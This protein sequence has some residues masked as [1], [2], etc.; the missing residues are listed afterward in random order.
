LDLVL[1]MTHIEGHD[2][3]DCTQI[4]VIRA[5]HVAAV[6]TDEVF[7]RPSVDVLQHACG[8]RAVHT[9]AVARWILIAHPF[10][11]PLELPD[12]SPVKPEGA[13]TEFYGRT[14]TNVLPNVS[15]ALGGS[16]QV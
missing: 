3:H 16:G 11:G 15:I 6:V 10:I 9:G 14:P 5:P 1:G 13:D 2:A 4:R 12:V 8:P 7:R